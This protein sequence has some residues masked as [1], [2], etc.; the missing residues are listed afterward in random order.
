MNED[1]PFEKPFSQPCENNKDFIVEHLA[2]HFSKARRVLEIGSG[3]GQHA[4]YFAQQLPHLEWHT[5]DQVEYHEGIIAWMNEFPNSN[6]HAPIPLSFPQHDLPDLTFDAIFS[7]NTA[8]IMLRNQVADMM[9]KISASLPSKGIFCQYGPFLVNG[10]FSSKS[11]EEFHHKL[12]DSGRGGYRDIEELNAWAP[13][14]TLRH[15]H[16]MPANNL[17]LVWEK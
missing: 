11:N 14:L 3:T 17:L 16:N 4:V 6:L 12:I 9:A 1:Q 7:A 13:A 5:A 2:Q 8:H 15:I 10:K